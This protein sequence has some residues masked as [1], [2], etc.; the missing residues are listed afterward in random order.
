MD[1]PQLSRVSMPPS[2]NE[3]AEFATNLE[4]PGQV[5][6]MEEIS[7]EI[8][9][10][11]DLQFVCGCQRECYN[12]IQF[13]DVP[14]DRRKHFRS[15]TFLHSLLLMWFGGVTWFVRYSVPLYLC[16]ALSLF[17]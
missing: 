12:K 14:W 2:L 15:Q 7:D 6:E 16:Y 4:L 11:N 1:E 8:V 3:D 10:L 9:D 5:S 13:T 17:D